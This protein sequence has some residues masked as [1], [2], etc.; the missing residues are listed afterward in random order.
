MKSDKFFSKILW[1]LSASKVINNFPDAVVFIDKDGYITQMNRK[2]GEI[3][4]IADGVNP[5]NIDDIITDGMRSVE[6]SIKSKRPILAQ[7]NVEGHCFYVELTATTK[8]KGYC[9]SIRT[10]TQT[11][12]EKDTEHKILKF[13][14]EKNAMLVKVRDD[15]CEPVDSIISFTKTLLSGNLD[16]NQNKYANIVK[17]K[18]EEHK[19]YL[20]K[21]LDFTNAE[22]L[23]YEPE[24]KRFDVV[25]EIKQILKNINREIDF[26]YSTL[27]NHSFYTDYKAFKQII[28]NII[29]TS[30]EMTDNGSIGIVLSSADTESALTFGLEEGKK[31]IQITVQDTGVGIEPDEKKTL[32][33]P[34]FHAGK[35][36]FMRALRLGIASILIKRCDGFIDITSELMRGTIYNI[37]IQE[38]DE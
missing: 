2:A 16:E 24:Y 31:Y 37:V 32:C 23:I 17:N 4:I 26:D 10:K 29:E 1:F 3:F 14:N 27:E 7:A 21:L 30:C 35:K 36:S 12:I 5:V 28:T 13:N 18:A 34:Y 20:N 9:I 33:D 38:K 19:K 15:I 6:M 11:A 8:N 25:L 22:S